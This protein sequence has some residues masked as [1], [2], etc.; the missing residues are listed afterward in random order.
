MLSS[1]PDYVYCPLPHRGAMMGCFRTSILNSFTPDLLA[2]VRESV[3][4]Q[5]SSRVLP[6][7]V[8]VSSLSLTMAGMPEVGEPCPSFFRGRAKP[9][10]SPTAA[11]GPAPRPRWLRTEGSDPQESAAALLATLPGGD[12]GWCRRRLTL[13]TL[14]SGD[15]RG[16]AAARR[17]HT[18]AGRR[19]DAERSAARA[20]RTVYRPG[21]PLD[22]PWSSVQ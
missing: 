7:V 22:A 15:R 20:R 18:E 21:M 16:G 17:P 19:A 8:F 10:R 1:G 5:F 2:A 3:C 14:P 11:A 12:S 13:A 6:N 9:F 4:L